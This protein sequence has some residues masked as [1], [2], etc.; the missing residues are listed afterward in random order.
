MRSVRPRRAVALRV[1]VLRLALL[2]AGAGGLLSSC[3]GSHDAAATARV[4]AVQAVAAE[5]ASD[6]A[7]TLSPRNPTEE[8]VA[9][10]DSPAEATRL[11]ALRSLGFKADLASAVPVLVACLDDPS[12][13]VARASRDV[14]AGYAYRNP[15]ALPLDLVDRLLNGEH[16][17]DVDHDE[18]GMYLVASLGK[19]GPES[20]GILNRIVEQGGRL[21]IRAGAALAAIEQA[22][23]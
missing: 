19:R 15:N 1:P 9:A 18:P 7:P 21:G 17:S 2:T 12:E 6:S 11:L 4:D 16:A 8:L 22:R 10:L 3:R 13:K 14:L 23:P 20:V 5:A